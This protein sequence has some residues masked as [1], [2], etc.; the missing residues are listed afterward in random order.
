[1][2][3][4]IVGS[5]QKNGDVLESQN[6]NVAVRHARFVCMYEYVSIVYD[7]FR[8]SMEFERVRVRGQQNPAEN[9]ANCALSLVV[10][11]VVERGR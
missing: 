8:R 7:Y 6:E 11:V 2:K 3:N 10:C 1:V 4:K 9:P 5:V